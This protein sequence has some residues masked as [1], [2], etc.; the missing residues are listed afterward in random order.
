MHI[1]FLHGRFNFLGLR[2]D[3]QVSDSEIH[4]SVFA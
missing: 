3:G 1:S 4:F 2:L